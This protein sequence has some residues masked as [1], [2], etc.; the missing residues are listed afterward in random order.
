MT[1]YLIYII[2][3]ALAL[4][5]LYSLYGLFLRRETFH[6]LNRKMLLGILVASMVLPFCQLAHENNLSAMVQHIE[7]NISVEADRL[8]ESTEIIGGSPAMLAQ[9]SAE[10][11]SPWFLIPLIIY[12]TGLAYFWTRQVMAYASLCLLIRRGKRADDSRL[13]STDGNLLRGTRLILNDQVLVPCSWMHWILI[14]TRDLNENGQMVIHH[15]MEHIRRHHSWDMLL[16]DFTVNML[17]FLPFAHLL[18]KDLSDV[19]EYQ[20]DRAVM[21]SDV[22]QQRYHQLLIDKA[23]I[24]Q[25][26]TIANSLNASEVKSRLTMMFRKESS[27]LSRLKVL[28]VLPLLGIVLMAFARPNLVEEVRQAIAQEEVKAEAVIKEVVAPIIAPLAN[29]EVAPELQPKPE[30]PEVD[31]MTGET[32]S[33][34]SQADTMPHLLTDEER[35]LQ[36]EAERARRVEERRKARLKGPMADDGLPIF[37]DLPLNTNPDYLY[38]GIWLERKDNESQLHIVHTFEQD[39]EILYL[40]GEDSYIRLRENSKVFYKCRG[41]NIARAFD[42]KFHVCGMRGKTVDFILLFPAIPEEY[43]YLTLINIKPRLNSAVWYTD[44][45]FKSDLEPVN[46]T[47]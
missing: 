28:Y 43:S 42:T 3:W 15:E 16:C 45:Y 10:A 26:M 33:A 41:T 12:L 9:P 13:C 30:M 19:H 38:E 4:T 11:P 20:A 1:A 47:R 6:A 32:Y 46:K 18:R 31:E 34:E 21:E 17:W 27:R 8:D 40:A 29:E 37:Y 7:Q 14:S 25:P 2:K 35:V 23:T 24:G 44:T 22:D 39:D 5:A 36:K